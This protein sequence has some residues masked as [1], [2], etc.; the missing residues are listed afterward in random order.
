[1]KTRLAIFDFDGTITRRDTFLPFLFFCFGCGKVF[2]TAIT[3]IPILL[4]YKLRLISNSRAKEIVFEKF[5]R[6]MGEDDFNRLSRSYSLKRISP[7]VRIKALEKIIR[8]GDRGDRVMII[9]ASMENWIKPWA[10]VH[11]IGHVIATTVE[12]KDGRLTGRFS[13]PN[14]HG[15][16]KV[17]RLFETMGS[18]DQY[19]IC[20]YGD[21]KGDRDLLDLSDEPFYRV[22]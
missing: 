3:S 22:F 1:M 18:L 6:G 8:H 2:F 21:S 12:I 20:S 19:H 5:F 7:G 16:E 17:R 10:D 15:K 13:S 11:G 9:S 14:C 4:M